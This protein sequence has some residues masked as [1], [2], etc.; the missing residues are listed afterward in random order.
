MTTAVVFELSRGRE[1]GEQALLTGHAFF[2]AQDVPESMAEQ[3]L[4]PRT[5]L[6]DQTRDEFHVRME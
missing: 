4:H 1:R 3:L 5:K 6:D 2:C